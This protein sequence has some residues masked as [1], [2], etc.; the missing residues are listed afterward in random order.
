[1]DETDHTNSGILHYKFCLKQPPP[2]V[3]CNGGSTTLNSVSAE[4]WQL[5]QRLARDLLLIDYPNVVPGPDPFKK[6][7]S[8]VVKLAQIRGFQQNFLHQFYHKE[9]SMAS[10]FNTCDYPTT[11]HIVNT[12]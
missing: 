5:W 8:T 1:M 3:K 12:D 4:G 6:N 11:A 10:L 7:L 2:H 9:Q